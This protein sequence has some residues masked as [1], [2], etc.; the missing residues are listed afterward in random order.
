MGKLLVCMTVVCCLGLP[1]RAADWRLN[2]SQLPENCFG[3][4]DVACSLQLTAFNCPGYPSSMAG[5]FRTS[6]LAQRQ[7]IEQ[8]LPRTGPRTLPLNSEHRQLTRV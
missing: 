6:C 1:S 3:D 5:Y 7:Y 2:A 4:R 8:I